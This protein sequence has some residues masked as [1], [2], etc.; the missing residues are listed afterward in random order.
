MAPPASA[1]LAGSAAVT[2]RF[3]HV[4]SRNVC[5]LNCFFFVGFSLES[6]YRIAWCSLG[7][8]YSVLI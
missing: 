7:K 5:Y 3:S 6:T 4:K 2:G 8:L 1:M